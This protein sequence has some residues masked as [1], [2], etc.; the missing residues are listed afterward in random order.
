MSE[1]VDFRQSLEKKIQTLGFDFH[2]IASVEPS[3]HMDFYLDWL[4]DGSHGEMQYLARKDSVSRRSDLTE[5]LPSAQTAL[6]VA[7]NYF[8]DDSIDHGAFCRVGRRP[9]IGV[10]D[11]VW[12]GI[13][14]GRF[15]TVSVGVRC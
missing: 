4:D 12:D 15:L 9:P 6:V 1:K 7:Q 8:Q 5:T 10:D 14:D 11:K 13:H 3:S 2:G